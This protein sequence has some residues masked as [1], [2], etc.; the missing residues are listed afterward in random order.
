MVVD[1]E[2]QSWARGE[3]AEPPWFTLEDDELFTAMGFR[4]EA[5]KEAAVHLRGVFTPDV[6][7]EIAADPKRGNGPVITLFQRSWPGLLIPFLEVGRDL[8][9]VQPWSDPALLKRLERRAT[10]RETAF[11]LRVLANV[12]RAGY[13][14][15]RIPE[16]PSHR[17]PDLEVQVGLDTYEL[18]L[19]GVS[20]SPID[21]A[22]DAVSEALLRAEVI[23][24]GLHLELRGSEELSARTFENLNA[25]LAEL[26]HIVGAFEACC[27][28]IR[29]SGGKPGVYQVP[30][31]GMIHAIPGPVDGSVT[32][33]VLPD[34][35]AEKRVNKVI[36]LVRDASRQF[37]Q[38]RG[39]AVVGVRRSAHMLEAAEAIQ[40]AAAEHPA[41]FAKC[42]M[43]VLVDDLR[44]PVRDYGSIPLA[45]PVQVHA[46]RQMSRA[47]ERLAAVA[48][49]RGG[50]SAQFIRAA[51]PGELGVQVGTVRRAMTSTVI[52]PD[53]KFDVNRAVPGVVDD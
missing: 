37:T 27:T 40:A 46:R 52:G 51:R 13:R 3:W 4:L 53:G 48:A 15:K 28:A 34:L 6:C 32:P 20:D 18:E 14:A 8:G 19:K 17:T 22:A 11:E 42:H 50:R 31:Y 26:P 41:A 24:G 33:V 38:R 39:I 21:E 1:D 16:N 5:R 12:I 47:Q 49:G 10:F 9:T 25:V 43:V 35:P 44:D 36:R 2:L 29:E 23:V 7:R 45:L 30:G